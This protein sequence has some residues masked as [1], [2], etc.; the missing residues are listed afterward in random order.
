[1]RRTNPV[2]ERADASG[3]TWSRTRPAAFPRTSTAPT[4]NA[5]FEQL[6]AS[7]QAGLGTAQVGLIHL[8]AVFQ[9]LS[10]GVDHRPA[11][12]VQ[13]C[14][15]RLVADPELALQLDRRQPGG[16]GRHQISSPEPD[17]QRHPGPMQDGAGRPR[18]LPATRL[19][20]P[21]PPLRQLE[22]P[23]GPALATS[24][25]LGPAARRQVLPA[26]LLIPESRL[27]LLQRLGEIGPTHSSTL[28]MGAFG[29]N[30][31]GST[32]VILVPVSA[33]S[34][35]TPGASNPP[36]SRRLP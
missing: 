13:E 19:A 26:P 25:P 1:M 17:R 7:L 31:I 36:G 23:G 6:A 2:S 20:L 28:R 10:L 30:P 29:V 3:T 12:L 34:P 5:L 35:G 4:T 16:M 22:G 24:K 14:P 15:G 9:R 33:G 21:Q 11:E 8:D 18:D 32:G 27:K